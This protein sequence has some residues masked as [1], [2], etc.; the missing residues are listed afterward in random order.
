M[1][2]TIFWFSPQVSFH[3]KCCDYKLSTSHQSGVDQV[4]CLHLHV[5]IA[6]SK[7]QRFRL[8]IKKLSLTSLENIK[9]LRSCSFMLLKCGIFRHFILLYKSCKNMLSRQCIPP[10]Y[11]EVVAIDVSVSNQISFSDIIEHLRI[12]ASSCS[13]VNVFNI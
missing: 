9:I 4:L 13:P 10:I 5:D 6:V 12:S 3:E 11:G 2:P 1:P 7:L 8:K